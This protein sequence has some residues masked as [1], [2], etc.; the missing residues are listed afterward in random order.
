NPWP[1]WSVYALLQV[2][3][4]EAEA[5]A[6]FAGS[7]LMGQYRRHTTQIWTIYM[8]PIMARGEWSGSN[9]FRPSAELDPGNPCI[10]AITRA[11]IR[12]NKLMPFWRYVPTSQKSL[13]GNG[14]L[15]FTKGIGEAPIVQMA[16][17][18]IWK[19]LE[20]LNEFAY[21]SREH[22]GAIQRT[23]DIR[24]YRE[25]LFSRFQPYRTEGS[26]DG[27]ELKL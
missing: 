3:D 21:R 22:I 2:W 16:T 5:A 19:N 26:W 20:S 13:A 25:E 24:W 1:D 18:S 14:G 17:F 4:N 9:P 7:D 10:A 11:T 15:L 8:R 6:F 23:R 12:W 27:V